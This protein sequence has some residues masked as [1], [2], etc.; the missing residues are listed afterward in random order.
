LFMGRPF[1]AF[2]VI[3]DYN[4][5][6]LNITLAKSITSKKVIEELEKLIPMA[7]QTRVYSGR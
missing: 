5:E 2:N 4:R 7:R 1:R 3:D 6:A